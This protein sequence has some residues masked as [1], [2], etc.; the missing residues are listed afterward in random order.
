MLHT[1]EVEFQIYVNYFCI[2]FDCYNDRK[3]KTSFCKIHA[4]SVKNT[5]STESKGYDAGKKISDI[6][7]SMLNLHSTPA[8]DSDN[9]ILLMPFISIFLSCKLSNDSVPVVSFCSC[10]L[11]EGV[12]HLTSTVGSKI[13]RALVIV[14]AIFLWF[15]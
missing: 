1:F 7:H 13:I 2:A 10:S 5:G 8:I 15:D 6:K 11:P 12:C 4:Q 14:L 9:K 3:E